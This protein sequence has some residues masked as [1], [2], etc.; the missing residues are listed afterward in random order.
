MTDTRDTSFNGQVVGFDGSAHAVRTEAVPES[1]VW[2]LLEASRE[3]DVMVVAPHRRT[4]ALGLQ[5]GP[6]V[7]ALLHHAQCP[8]VLVPMA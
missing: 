8:V 2:A 7:H 4:R 3:A 5:L 1:P 6:V